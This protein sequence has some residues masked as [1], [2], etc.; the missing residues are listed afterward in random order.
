L[1]GL[2][3][4]INGGLTFALILNPIACGITFLTLLFAI[5]FAWRQT[6]L[7]AFIGVIVG[8]IAAVLATIAFAIDITVMA[9]AKKNVEK[10]SDNFHVKY[11]QTT[12]MTLVAM[13]LLW[14]AVI[15]FCIIGIRGR[16]TK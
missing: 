16:R 8:V 7:S 14:I 12:W 9:L 10:L 15:I 3:N 2:E 5:W 13:I 11:E 1:Q 4:A 6:R